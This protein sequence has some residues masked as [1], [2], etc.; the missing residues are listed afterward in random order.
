MGGEHGKCDP[1]EGQAVDPELA[2][3]A[4]T[5]NL[6]DKATIE[7]RVMGDDRHASHK[8]CQ[9]R[10][11]LLGTRSVCDID[12][13]NMRERTYVGRNGAAGI[14]EGP[15]AL[16]YLLPDKTCGCYLYEFA[17]LK[18]EPR[19]FGVENDDSLLEGPEVSVRGFIGKPDI[20]ISHRSCHTRDKQGGY[21]LTHRVS[22]AL[23]HTR[24]HASVRRA[25]EHPRGPTGQRG[26]RAQKTRYQHDERRRAKGSCPSC[27]GWS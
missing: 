21:G 14:D 13:A 19:R 22:V 25:R 17:V 7:A 9:K 16:C 10:N 15:K 26:Y 27:R 1:R 11:G 24:V 5:G 6:L 4:T 2:H 3:L 20:C 18:R 12:V 8:V 23:L